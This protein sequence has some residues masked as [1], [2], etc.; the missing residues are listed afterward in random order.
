MLIE[1]GLKN[2]KAFGGELQKAPLS[3]I[4]LIYGPNSGGKS[5][6]IQALLMLKQSEVSEFHFSHF[7]E[8]TGQLAHRGEYVDLGSFPSLIHKQEMDR[9]MEILIS[10][11]GYAHGLGEHYEEFH[12]DKISAHMAFAF[13]EIRATTDVTRFKYQVTNSDELLVDSGWGNVRGSTD[14]TGTSKYYSA[15]GIEVPHHIIGINK[16]GFLPYPY[17][18]GLAPQPAINWAEASRR[19]EVVALVN[20]LQQVLHPDQLTILRSTDPLRAFSNAMESIIYLGPL[21]SYPERIYAISSKDS[22]TTGIR[23]EHTHD[24]LFRSEETVESVNKWFEKFSIPYSLAVDRFEGMRLSGEYVSL[25]LLDK[26]TSTNVTLS[27]VGF[28]VNQLLPM[29]VEG[30]TQ[31]PDSPLRPKHSIICIEQPEIHIHPRLQAEVADLLIAT[32]Q[33]ER[34]KQWIVETHSEMLIRRIQ[35]RIAEK[36]ISPA[37]VSVIYVNPR[38]DIGS[39]ILLLRLD[40]DGDF[41]DDWPEG[42]FEEGFNEVMSY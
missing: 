36:Q 21:R 26:F 5:S 2:F 33:E 20:R 4:N 8:T 24:I 35:R 19:E 12:V 23:G 9:E 11:D 37:D 34:G 15:A 3:K 28:G 31:I 17:V 10:Y 13:P 42:F 40:E 30:V 25:M 32:S 22:R 41:L 6:I 27:D 1:L 16:W 29:I 38:Q 14:A 7:D 39:E 18:E